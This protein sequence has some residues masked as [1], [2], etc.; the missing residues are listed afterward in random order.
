LLILFA[1]LA[2]ADAIPITIKKD[3]NIII[4]ENSGI[5]EVGEGESIG[6]SFA[7]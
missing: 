2:S 4:D 1:F 7:C 6:V 5:V 3:A